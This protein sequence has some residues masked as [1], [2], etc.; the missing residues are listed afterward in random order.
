MKTINKSTFFI[1]IAIISLS[2]LTNSVLAQTATVVGADI[3]VAQT[4]YGKVRGYIHD[5]TYIYKGIPYAQAKRFLAPPDNHT[6]E[7]VIVD[8]MAG[9]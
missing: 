9:L 2:V 6:T 7:Q 4:E 1:V 8:A 3:A 5:G